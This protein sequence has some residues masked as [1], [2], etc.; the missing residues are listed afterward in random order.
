MRAASV[1]EMYEAQSLRRTRIFSFRRYMLV[2]KRKPYFTSLLVCISLG[3]AA[4]EGERNCQD[5]WG[6]ETLSDV[7]LGNYNDQA[8]E[9]PIQWV[10]YDSNASTGWLVVGMEVTNSYVLCYELLEVGSLGLNHM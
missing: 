4:A 6:A 2:P 5:A 3:D 1:T 8:R 7:F 9:I 10:C